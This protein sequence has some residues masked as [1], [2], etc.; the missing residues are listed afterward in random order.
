[1]SDKQRRSWNPPAP[2]PTPSTAPLAPVGLEESWER[3]R[4]DAE[5]VDPRDLATFKGTATVVLHNV[6]AGVASLV[7]ERPWFEQQ[8]DGPKVDFARVV[9][10]VEAAEALVF[11]ASRA[12]RR[13]SATRDLR[14]RITKARER[15]ETLRLAGS[16]L[17]RAGL[18]AEVP[19]T[20]GVGPTAVARDLVEYASFFRAQRPKTRNATAVT[21]ELIR[22]SAQLGTDLLRDIT[23]KGAPVRRQRTEAE[24][25][26][27]EAR[28]RVAVVVAERYH[29]VERAAGWRWGA[30]AAEHVPGMLARDN[31][32][33][34]AATDEEGATEEEDD[35]ALGE[36][37]GE[38][39][40]ARD[41][42]SEG[43]TRDDGDDAGEDDAAEE[44]A[45]KKSAPKAA[46]P[47][48]GNAKAAPA[49]GASKA[50][51]KGAPKAASK[52]RTKTAPTSK[53][54]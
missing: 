5:R 18:V 12:S 15:L 24:R 40:A 50:A 25:A 43:A 22:E 27:S 31:G 42:A 47:K 32:R 3:T 4:P 52:T 36:G 17:V 23:P 39:D 37:E 48:T 19:P 34:G 1:M 41:D 44:P 11:L 38:D 26:A 16:A 51:A 6:R 53:T 21:P 28:D 20:T 33:G 35:E 2:Q 30:A 49:A 7:A 9:S 54:R 46:A 45:A 8:A 13:A 29:Y 10:A 14:A